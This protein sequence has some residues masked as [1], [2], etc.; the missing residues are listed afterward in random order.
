MK[1][2]GA[3]RHFIFAFLIALI[4]YALFYYGI[5]HRRAR[6]GAWQVA[7]T[8]NAEGVPALIINQSKLALTNVQ[9][10]FAGETMSGAHRGGV[11]RFDQPQPVPCDVPF[12]KCVFMDLTFLPGTVTLQLFGHEIE[13]LPRVLM[14]D[15][16]EH[17]WR[18][19][20]VT[21]LRREAVTSAK[22]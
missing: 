19:E 8:N 5:E 20:S 2:R 15:H 18:S 11:M 21:T 10:L 16:E 13:L 3:A 17:P 14:I 9:V 12:G 4:G 6:K 7:F 22:P 1:S